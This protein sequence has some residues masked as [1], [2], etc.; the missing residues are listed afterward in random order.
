MAEKLVPLNFP[1]GLQNNGTDYQSKGRWHDA[2]LVRFHQGTI[3]PIGGWVTRTLTG[4]TM[5]GVACA[6]HAWMMN[7]GSSY[8]AVGTSTGLFVITSANVVSNITPTTGSIDG[9][10]STPYQWDLTNFGQALIAVLRTTVALPINPVFAGDP[11]ATNAY[12]WSG[13]GIAVE[14]YAQDEGPLSVYGCCA[15]PERFL[16]FLGGGDPTTYTR[17]ADWTD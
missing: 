17:P 10:I 1:P 7:D 2:N 3:Q 4:A 5:T 6:S 8:L 9:A 16:L 14:C 13:S 15:T 12:V 11:Q